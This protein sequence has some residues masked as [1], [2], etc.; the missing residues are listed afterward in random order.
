MN[1]FAIE[2]LTILAAN[3]AALYG[4]DLDALAPLAAQVGPTVAELAEP[5][6]ELPENPSQGLAR[7]MAAGDKVLSDDMDAAAL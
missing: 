5:L 1:A 6:R 3:A 4:F 7:G 2:V